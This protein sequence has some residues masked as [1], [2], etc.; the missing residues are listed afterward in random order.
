MKA[1][2]G[3]RG[4]AYSLTSPLEGG[5][6]STRRFG[7]FTLG[8]YIRYPWYRRLAWFQH[9]SGLAL[10]IFTLTTFDPRTI[11]SIAIPHTDW[12]IPAHILS[13]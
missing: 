2:I 1:R 9:P 5:D 4:T 7:R 13:P 11:H 10:N 8:K 6:W 3:C 12:A